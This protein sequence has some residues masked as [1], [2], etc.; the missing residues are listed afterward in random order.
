M[1]GDRMDILLLSNLHGN[2]KRFQIWIWCISCQ[3]LD[4]NYEEKFSKKKQK[5]RNAKFEIRSVAFV[6]LFLSFTNSKRPN[7]RCSRIHLLFKWF[8]SLIFFFVEIISSWEGKKTKIFEIEIW[9]IWE[10]FLPSI[11]VGH[12]LAL[13]FWCLPLLVLTFLTFL[14]LE[15]TS[16]TKQNQSY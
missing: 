12:C 16:K 5:L 8:R 10:S 7:I 15:P 11:W 2:F 14:K 4:H 3:N 9:E 1:I 13:S 6:C